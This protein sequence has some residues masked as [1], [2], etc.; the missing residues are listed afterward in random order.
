[1]SKQSLFADCRHG[2][3]WHTKRAKQGIFTA[4]TSAG[5]NALGTIKRFSPQ[6]T[7]LSRYAILSLTTRTIMVL[8]V[9]E[10]C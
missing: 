7:A 9:S 6:K 2:A 4:H 8:S 5:V 1:M 10:L 3:E